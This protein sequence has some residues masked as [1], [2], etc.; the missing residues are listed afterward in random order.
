MEWVNAEV[1]HIKENQ[2][3]DGSFVV[4]WNWGN[5]YKEYEIAVNWWKSDIIIK[6]MLY[7]KAIEGM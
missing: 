4:P 3:S 6:K 7:L 2:L 5:D 1:K